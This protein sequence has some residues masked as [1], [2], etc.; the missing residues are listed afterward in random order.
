VELNGYP[1]ALKHAG[2]GTYQT[3]ATDDCIQVTV[4]DDGPGID[5][6]TLPKA[7]LVSGF[8]TAASLG[9]GFTIMLQLCSRVLLY[10]RPGRTEVGLEWMID[11]E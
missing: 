8:S 11:P 4:T 9:V 2:R 1:P 7:T 10:T 3:F 6:R 5:F